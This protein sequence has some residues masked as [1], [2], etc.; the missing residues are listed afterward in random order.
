MERVAEVPVCRNKDDLRPGSDGPIA[1]PPIDPS[2][3]TDCN[4]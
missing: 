3:A 4:I 1:L 2:W